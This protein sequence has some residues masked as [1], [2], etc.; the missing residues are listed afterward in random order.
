M[1]VAGLRRNRGA[2]LNVS[3]APFSSVNDKLPAGNGV[4]LNGQLDLGEPFVNG[5]LVP[6][7]V[8]VAFAGKASYR[9]AVILGVFHDERIGLADVVVGALG[10][11]QTHGVGV[12]RKRGLGVVDDAGGEGQEDYFFFFG[13]GS[14]GNMA[15]TTAAIS[16]GFS[17]STRSIG[18]AP[19]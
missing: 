9:V 18:F 15:S 5:L 2:Q 14:W 6:D 10:G 4:L 3:R 12:S 7:A 1:R 19:S 13:R 17:L 11:N 8:D 16:V